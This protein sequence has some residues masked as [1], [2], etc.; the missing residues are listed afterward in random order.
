MS[1]GRPPCWAPP[2]TAA[3]SL[4]AAGLLGVGYR[5]IADLLEKQRLRRV[6]ERY[7]S[8]AVLRSVLDDPALLQLGG[9]RKELTVFFS[10]IRGFTPYSETVG[11]MELTERLNEYYGEMIALAHARGATVDKLIGDSLMAFFGDPV[12]QP[13]HALRAVLAALDT[14]ERLRELAA[15]WRARGVHEFGVGIGIAT[16]EV[17]V[18]NLGSERFVDYTVV[19]SVVNLAARLQGA[20]A[21]GEILI[22]SRTYAL[23]AEH[24]EAESLGERTFKGI[25]GAH[26]VFRVLGRRP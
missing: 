20:A 11:P 22:A 8:P 25:A 24:I 17:A 9:A 6:Y 23:V 12:A 1:A 2:T 16:G 10:D 15:E 4:G 21:A 3:V 13:D 18:G 19:G 5:Q 26:E 14:Q 7:L